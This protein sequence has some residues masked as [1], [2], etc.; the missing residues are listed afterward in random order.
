MSI[1]LLNCYCD[2]SSS[3]IYKLLSFV[4]WFM[5]PS[6]PKSS[7]S[8]KE[9][10]VNRQLHTWGWVPR[11]RRHR[12]PCTCRERPFTTEPLAEP[13]WLSQEEQRSAGCGGR[14]GRQRGLEA[15]TS[16]WLGE[17]AT[18]TVLEWPVQDTQMVPRPAAAPP[19]VLK[20]QMTL[21]SLNS[22]KWLP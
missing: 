17:T 21:T 20:W 19:S 6:S 10:Q 7:Q 3:R 1:F 5:I 11:K 13:S 16:T 4:L 14:W 22:G 9:R 8:T 2:F 18:R 12:G 15:R